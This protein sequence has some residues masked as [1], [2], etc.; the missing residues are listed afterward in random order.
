MTGQDCGEIA[1]GFHEGR[2][3]HGVIL[4]KLDGRR[5]AVRRSSD[6]PA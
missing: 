5:A 6:S 3:A 2:G 4:T 1:R